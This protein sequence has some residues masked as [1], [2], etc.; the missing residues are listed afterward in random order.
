MRVS[1][2][3]SAL[4]LLVRAMIARE[5]RFG[6]ALEKGLVKPHEAST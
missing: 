1:G 6:H 5:A 2:S 4:R 3:C